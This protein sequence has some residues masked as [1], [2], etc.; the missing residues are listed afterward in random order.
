MRRRQ[1]Q[2]RHDALRRHTANNANDLAVRVDGTVDP[3]SP[4]WADSQNI[5]FDGPAYSTLRG[6]NDLTNLDL[7]QVGATSDEFASLQ[8]STS[9][10]SAG[11][12]IGGGGG[13]TIG[14]GGG[15]TIGGGGGVTIGGGGGVTM[16]AAAASLG[17]G[18]GVTIGGGGGV[19]IGGGGGA[20]TELDYLTANSIVRPPTSPGMTPS[21]AGVTPAYVIITWNPPAFGVVETYTIYR[22]VNGAPRG[23]DRQRKRGERKSAGYNMDRFQS[24]VRNRG[25]HDNDHPLF[26]CQSIPRN[27]RVNLRRRQ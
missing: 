17:G 22:S 14:G 11:V 26:P 20:T 3:L 16:A 21:P 15:V 13:V 23:R 6:Y 7:R 19:T 2:P 1:R 27:A 25:L 5:A 18:G 9:Y 24:C 4:T 10:G 12:T 8:N